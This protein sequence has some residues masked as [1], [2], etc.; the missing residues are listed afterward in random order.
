MRRCYTLM[1]V[2]LWLFSN[3]THAQDYTTTELY[4]NIKTD[5]DEPV[6]HTP[7]WLVETVSLQEL[8]SIT[9]NKGSVNFTV[10]K[11]KTYSV[12]FKDKKEHTLITISPKQSTLLAKTIRY[13]PTVQT[14]QTE[15]ITLHQTDTVFQQ[16]TAGTVVHT[17]EILVKIKILNMDQ[18]PLQDMP[19]SL[20]NEA[21]HTCYVANT[22]D[23]GQACFLV[24]PDKE[25]HIGLAAFPQYQTFSTPAIGGLTVER[26]IKFE[27][28]AMVIQDTIHDTIRQKLPTEVHA[29]S[30]QAYVNVLVK[31]YDGMALAGEKVIVKIVDDNKHFYFAE[32]NSNGFA[33]FLLPKGKKYVVNFKYDADVDVWDYMDMRGTVRSEVEYTYIG[34]KKLDED[35]GLNYMNMT[36][37]RNTDNDFMLVKKAMKDHIVHF[38]G[39]LISGFQDPGCSKAFIDDAYSNFLPPGKYDLIAT[40]LPKA[41]SSTFDGI[42]IPPDTRLII[43]SGANFTGNVLLNVTGPV[44][45]NNLIWEE[46]DLYSGANKKYYE[47]DLQKTFPPEH[48]YWS[49]S[50]M[51][52]WQNGSLEVIQIK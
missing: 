32:T 9:N 7:I 22:N 52:L 37:H 28:S 27:P 29:T 21:S 34:S 17:T 6:T 49:A 20:M 46:V 14:N 8:P 42:A 35:A 18:Q 45:I 19:V 16:L 43:Y 10:D 30:L 11:G 31:D 13:N 38:S 47:A 3:Q 1:P 26:T 44:I 41:V 12:N 51:H 48:R 39:G 4:L 15:N 40:S 5:A 50:D 33:R 25:Y 23:K 24:Y 36:T 2:I